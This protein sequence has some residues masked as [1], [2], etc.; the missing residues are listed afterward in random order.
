[1]RAAISSIDSETTSGISSTGFAINLDTAGRLL[2]TFPVPL[3]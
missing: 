1:M 3:C 2:L